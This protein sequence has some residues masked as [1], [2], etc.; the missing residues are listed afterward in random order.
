MEVG[1]RDEQNKELQPDL[2][3]EPS[4]EPTEEKDPVDEKIEDFIE[5]VANRPDLKQAGGILAALAAIAAMVLLFV[6]SCS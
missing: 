6:E 3:Q 2:E 1:S 5:E 4:V